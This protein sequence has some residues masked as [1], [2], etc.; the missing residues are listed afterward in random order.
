MLLIPHNCLSGCFPLYL[1]MLLCRLLLFIALYLHYHLLLIYLGVK[2]ILMV[3]LSIIMLVLIRHILHSLLVS[4]TLYIYIYGNS[5]RFS[6]VHRQFRCWYFLLH[7]ICAVSYHNILLFFLPPFIGIQIYQFGDQQTEKHY[8]DGT[9]EIMFNDGTVK[10]IYSNGD[11]ASILPDGRKIYH[12]AIE[13]WRRGWR[14]AR[15]GEGR[16]WWGWT[17][18]CLYWL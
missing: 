7:L 13:G 5:N 16:G 4:I 9:K 15:P 3:G 1:P 12:S 10:Y 2:P 8:S 17:R 6:H 18:L 11:S 14:G